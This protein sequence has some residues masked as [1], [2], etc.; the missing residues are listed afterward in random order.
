MEVNPSR[1]KLS[2]PLNFH[3]PGLTDGSYVI[4]VGGRRKLCNFHLL[5]FIGQ[6]PME[7]KMKPTKKVFFRGFRLIFH[8]PCPMEVQQF[9]VVHQ[10]YTTT[11]PSSRLAPRDRSSSRPALPLLPLPCRRTSASSSGKAGPAGV[12]AL[13]IIVRCPP[14]FLC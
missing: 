7:D 9:P 8:R 13:Y 1:W 3:Q 2:P 10:P 5:T 6:G 12:T 4:F 14:R 11:P